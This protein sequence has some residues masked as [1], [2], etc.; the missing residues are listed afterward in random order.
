MLFNNMFLSI[1]FL[2]ITWLFRLQFAIALESDETNSVNTCNL[3][4]SL[5]QE[6]DS[7]EPFVHAIINE[8]LYGSFKGTTWNELAY[9]VDTFGPRFTGTA[10]LER[11]IDYVLNKSLEFGL[12]NVHGE[13]VSVPHWVR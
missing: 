6:I 5:I 10:V 9:F 2:I 1:K 12:D 3:P 8:T 7:Y 4:Q 11:S 13:S